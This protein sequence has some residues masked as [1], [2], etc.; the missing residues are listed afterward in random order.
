LPKG[1]S[2]VAV[3]NRS[4]LPVERLVDLSAPESSALRPADPQDPNG[5]SVDR[6]D[7]AEDIRL[8]PKQLLSKVDRGSR[9]FP[10]QR[11][12]MRIRVERLKR[13]MKT[14]EPASRSCRRA[15]RSEPIRGIKVFEGEL[16]QDDSVRHY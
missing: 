6:K 10:C 15:P 9:T 12:L 7:D 13:D 8:S 1:L 4:V 14:L 5:I 3:A 11:S 16:L 2:L